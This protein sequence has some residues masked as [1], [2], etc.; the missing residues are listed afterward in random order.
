MKT[1]CY[2]LFS[3]FLILFEFQSKAQML[4]GCAFLRGNRLEMGIANNGSYGAP[5]DAPAG[6]HTNNNPLFANTYNPVTGT[7]VARTFALGFVADYDSNGWANG[8]PPYFGDYFLP[9]TP[10]EGWSVE[11]NG[12]RCDAFCSEYQNNETTGFVG[13]LNGTNQSVNTNP[14][15]ISSDWVG[16]FGN[17]SIKQT[18][19]IKTNK[20]YC[21]G[22]VKFYNTGSTTLHNVYY[23]RTVDPDNDVSITN[24]FTTI[25]EITNQLPNPENKALV[26]CTSTI[27]TNAYLGLGTID[28]RAKAFVNN[29]GLFPPT[30]TL[31]YL[32]SGTHPDLT[33]TGTLTLDVGVGLVYQLG[34]ILPG[35]STELFF[36]YILSKNSF[37]EAVGDIHAHF[38]INGVSHQSGDTILYCKNSL[39]PVSITGAIGTN[40][41]WNS[42]A[43]L[44]NTNGLNNQVTLDSSMVVVQATING[45][46][47]DSIYF[48]LVPV[49]S[50]YSVYNVTTC[51]NLPYTLNGITYS[52]TGTYNQTISNPGACDSIITLNL[53]VTSATSSSSSVTASACISF[54][55]N[56]VNYSA[57]GIYTQTMTNASGCDSIITLHLTIHQPSNNSSNVSACSYYT[58]AGITFTNSGIYTHTFTGSAGCDSIVTI[59]LTINQP[60]SA[61]LVITEC[62]E[63]ILLGVTYNTSGSYTVH[64]TNAA[65]CDSTIFLT[66]T[67]L[68]IQSAILQNG[69]SL[70]AAVPASSYQWIQCKP[71]TII[72]G[73]T[74]STYTPTANGEYAL[75]I[76]NGGCIDTSDCLLFIMNAITEQDLSNS[77]SISPNPGDGMIHI[78]N[79][80]GF[81]N[82]TLNVTDISGK[83]ISNLFIEKGMDTIIDISSLSKGV[84]FILIDQDGVSIRKK[85]LK[86]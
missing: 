86:D 47:N 6:Y 51:N 71:F 41:N 44:S 37:N 81:K 27:D 26:S 76:D 52:V 38:N 17:L 10:Q 64:T 9:G 3:L 55:Y 66:L 49:D 57:S 39:V 24:N 4:N 30:D 32:Y 28:C 19:Q 13:I 84:Y 15:D 35:D 29:F 54:S 80:V 22:H 7:Y 8:T 73:A 40:W 12:S 65:G 21:T 42:N 70:L 61:N 85:L 56:S 33:Y 20:L 82:S 74:N 79:E 31:G 60:S 50:I 83:I 36:A 46:C 25:N 77:I 18:T 67:I 2:F 45:L 59:N 43:V 75:V 58:F 69:S 68:S 72:A 78:H 23:M 48:T 16:N 14:T 63:F 5:Q 1:T 53:N 11:V 34:D 62:N